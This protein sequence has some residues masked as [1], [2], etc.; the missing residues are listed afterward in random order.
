MYKHAEIYRYVVA[1][2]GDV[3]LPRW[4]IFGVYRLP[5]FT[6]LSG[7][8]VSELQSSAF[9]SDIASA[10]YTWLHLTN[11]HY[12]QMLKCHPSV[13]IFRLYMFTRLHKLLWLSRINV[14][15]TCFSVS[16]TVLLH[17]WDFGSDCDVYTSF[18]VLSVSCRCLNISHAVISTSY[19]CLHITLTVTS[20]TYRYHVS[21][22]LNRLRAA[23]G[24]ATS[25]NKHD[26][27]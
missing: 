2:N 16:G 13:H 14:Y 25:G 10:S 17:I 3:Y 26:I 5:M 1:S 23:P 27:D 7:R 19:G 21:S 22:S 12:I 8:H 20:V 18:F 15:G 11:D 6:Y 4:T 24:G 9:L